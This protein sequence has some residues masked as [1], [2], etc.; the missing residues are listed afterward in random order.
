MSIWL[1]NNYLL[2][3]FCDNLSF[4]NEK[5]FNDIQMVNY[6]RKESQEKARYDLNK[7]TYRRD[8]ALSKSYYIQS[9]INMMEHSITSAGYPLPPPPSSSSSSFLPEDSNQAIEE[10]NEEG[11]EEVQN[12]KRLKM[13]LD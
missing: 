7:Y 4:R 3:K 12:N 8:H 5:I 2:E 10:E 1:Q 13:D 6:N 9:Y 11:T